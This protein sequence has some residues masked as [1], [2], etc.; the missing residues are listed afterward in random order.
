MEG[1]IELRSIDDLQRK[2]GE[3]VLP[4]NEVV[5]EEI[6][7]CL[8][9]HAKSH[10]TTEE[11]LLMSSL[12]CTS[13]LLGKT[14]VEVFNTF[15]EIGN[16]YLLVVAPS[17]SGKSPACHLG[18]IDPI[19]GHIEPK[20]NKSILLDVALANG[21]FNHFVSSSTVPILCIDEAHSFLHKLS[22]EAKSSAAPSM[23]RLCKCFDG[24][25]WYVL[26]GD[27]GKR[28]GVSSARASLLAFTTPRQFLEKAWP[29][30]LQSENGLAERVL[31]FYQKRVERDLE[32][33]AEYC[34]KLN[35][36]PVKNLHTVFEQI[37]SEH[38]NDE[39]EKYT[40]SASAHEAFF[41]FAK[42]QENIDPTQNGNQVAA[43]ISKC[44][45]SKRTNHVL[46]V[47]LNMH[48]LYERVHKALHHET[49]P[50]LRCIA[51]RTI[52]MAITF[53][54]SLETFKAISEICCHLK[55]SETAVRLGISDT[56]I[57]KRLLDISGPYTTVKK[58]VYKFHLTE[59]THSISSKE[60]HGRLQKQGLG[61]YKCINKL[62]CYYKS[63][64]SEDLKP[65]L[66]VYGISLNSYKVIFKA[67]DD[68]VTTNI[69]EILLDNHP[70]QTHLKP[71]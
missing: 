55:P 39:K 1:E 45:N 25:C 51:L 57:Q 40:L 46:R 24:D 4:F 53:V 42:P 20:V 17:G 43:N 15:S 37:F 11:M 6:G 22:S 65:L 71:S 70:N 9:I 61:S 7:E 26:K 2:L 3:V 47:A 58:S 41:K 34:Q 30:I 10:G 31:F 23:E 63:L 56:D 64:P 60:L 35:D 19:V 14:T 5:P 29:K 13:S 44:Q 52:N 33:M 28:T 50:T 69:R 38:H 59:Q 8:R 68:R 32:E 48:I 54:E 49:G 27:K 36:L 66:S 12:A 67:E 62:H 18:C 16:L 21:L